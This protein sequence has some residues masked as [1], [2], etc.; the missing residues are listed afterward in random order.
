MDKIEYLYNLTLLNYI[1]E[2][3]IEEN[4]ILQTLLINFISKNLS[5]VQSTELIHN[6]IIFLHYELDCLFYRL[7]KKDVTSEVNTIDK[8]RLRLEVKKLS[9]SIKKT[10]LEITKNNN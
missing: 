10:Y 7:P 4:P 6:F 1:N 9:H 8:S 5:V 2:D 3:L